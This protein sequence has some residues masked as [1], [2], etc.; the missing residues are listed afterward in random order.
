M[1]NEVFLAVKFLCGFVSVGEVNTAGDFGLVVFLSLLGLFVILCL[2]DLPDSEELDDASCLSFILR[3]LNFLL[4]FENC[5]CLWL[6]KNCFLSSCLDVGWECVDFLG[7]ELEDFLSL[8]WCGIE[9]DF[10]DGV[11]DRCVDVHVF[12]MLVEVKEQVN[13]VAISEEGSL[14]PD[15]G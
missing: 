15:F 9:F 6:F 1:R 7:V 11:R 14:L 8:R 3:L 13:V 2:F 5:L 12:Q 4:S 10:E